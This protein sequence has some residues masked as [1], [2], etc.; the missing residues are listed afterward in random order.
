MFYDEELPA[1]FQDAD[2]EQYEM[3]QA[4]RA[5]HAARK[6]GRCTHQSVVGYRNPAVYP[7]QEGL[8]PGQSKCTDGCGEVFDSD[9]DWHDAMDAAVYG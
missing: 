9:E 6:A 8:R 7:E 3:E 5:I 1:G 2:I 4:G